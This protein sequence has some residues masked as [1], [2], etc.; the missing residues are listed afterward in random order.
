MRHVLR[1][2]IDIGAPPEQVW[3]HLVDLPAW[4]D[5]N[6]FITSAQGSATVGERL[7]LRM[8]PSG[9]RGMTIRPTVTVVS[10]GAALEWLGHLGVPGVFDGRHRF[11]LVATDGGT[12]LTQQE[13]FRGLLVRP[14]RSSLDRD[15]RAGFDAMND[16][17]R[18]RVLDASA[19]GRS[20][21]G[22]P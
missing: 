18:R 21:A 12:R 9:G 17:L 1:T 3:A 8:E 14:L 5:W 22:R 10:E 4:A 6:P 7:T 19:S 2:E 20:A 16:A 13:S 11:E 15:T